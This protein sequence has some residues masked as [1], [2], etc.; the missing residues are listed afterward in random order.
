MVQKM[1]TP[2]HHITF[3][4]AFRLN[5]FVAFYL[6]SLLSFKPLSAQDI[7][8]LE[9]VRTIQHPG[10][11]SVGMID[12]YFD[13]THQLIGYS[14]SDGSGVRD[15][16]AIYDFGR[17]SM[18]AK[19]PGYGLLAGINFIDAT[20][21]LCVMKDT[22]WRVTGIG[23]N[24]FREALEKGIRSM[25]LS[26]DLST[27]A[28][29][30]YDNG[31]ISVGM[32]AYDTATGILQT[33]DTIGSGTFSIDESTWLSFSP[34]DDYFA[35][36]GGYDHPY[37]Y[38]VDVGLKTLY[39]VS[40][41]DIESTYSPEFFFQQ[42]KLKLA[43]GGGYSNGAIAVIDIASLTQEGVM[44][45][46]WHYNY[47]VAFDRTGR[48]MVCGGYDGVL[49]IFEVAD[50]LFTEIE[51]YEVGTLR[52]LHF[53]S[54]NQYLLSGYQAAAGS[55]LD[56][57]RIIWGT[58]S[59]SAITTLPLTFYPNPTA[60]T[61]YMA[62]IRDALVKVYDSAG[63]LVLTQYEMGEGI[64]VRHLPSGYYIVMARNSIGQHIGKFVKE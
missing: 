1:Y 19:I 54:D 43:V 30:L 45:V 25:R 4:Q 34:G 17:D 52:S 15:T 18:L 11:Y 50:T 38:V 32:A 42:G 64:D 57:Q 33:I 56:I 48:Y 53:T 60:G 5:A 28:L 23:E 41:P 49:T 6:L 46:Y 21:L 3:A 13:S 27:V 40:T 14:I 2:A 61:I 55:R 51:S 31:N 58:T 20:E 16:L 10:N 47:A 35:L 62:G 59:V 24:I 36:N 26:N 44:P 29:V 9:L 12:S 8:G 22:L 37:V 63:Q 7:T 39:E